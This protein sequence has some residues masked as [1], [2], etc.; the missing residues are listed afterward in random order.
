[1]RPLFTRHSERYEILSRPWQL[2]LL[3]LAGWINRQQ[4]D[5]IDYLPTE[6]QVLKRSSETAE[7]SG[8]GGNTEDL[9]RRF[10]W[11]RNM[12]YDPIPMNHLAA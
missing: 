11:L 3:I 4:Q 6:N 10:F 8:Y 1:M 7:R 5:A 2:L 12:R 9:M